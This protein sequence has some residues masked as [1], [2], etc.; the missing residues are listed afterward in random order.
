M[1]GRGY[2]LHGQIE[3]KI[4]FGMNNIKGHSDLP[5]FLE[6]DDGTQIEMTYGKMVIKGM[7]FGDR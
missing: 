7:L 4:S 6:F 3:P 5:N 2:K 1:K